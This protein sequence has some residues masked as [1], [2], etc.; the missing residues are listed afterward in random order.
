MFYV[1]TTQIYYK[2][3]IEGAYVSNRISHPKWFH[4]ITNLMLIVMKTARTK[5]LWDQGLSV[6]KSVM[7][8]S[9][10]NGEICSHVMLLVQFWVC[11]CQCVLSLCLVSAGKE[12]CFERIVSRFGTNITYVVIGDGRDEEHAASQVKSHL[13][14]QASD[15]SPCLCCRQR[16]L[17][18]AR[19][20]EVW[21]EGSVCCYWGWCRRGAGRCQGNDPQVNQ[22]QCVT[23]QIGL[24]ACVCCRALDELTGSL[25]AS[26]ISS[27]VV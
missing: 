15:L 18:W 21:Q 8:F 14:P 26:F 3:I 19:Y 5:C 20:A 1:T 22:K 7:P 17:L 10:S 12:S 16:E 11:A 25:C 23:S 24:P 6:F 2:N 9:S 4:T 13:W 27:S